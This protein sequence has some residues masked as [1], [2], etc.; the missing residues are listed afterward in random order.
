MAQSSTKTGAVVPT[1]CHACGSERELVRSGHRT[2]AR[3]VSCGKLE[4]VAVVCAALEKW[5]VV[6]PDGKVQT[7]AT[8]AELVGLLQ[9]AV[10]RPVVNADATVIA[11][12]HAQATRR[13]PGV[14]RQQRKGPP[15]ADRGSR[16]Y[17]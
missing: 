8:K 6:G 17:R 3:C 2:A 9:G 10:A 15:R 4:D 14:A 12:L 1:T 7:F 16:E 11:D 5:S 13:L